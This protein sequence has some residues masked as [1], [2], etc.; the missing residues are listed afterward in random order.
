EAFLE[1]HPEFRLVEASGILAQQHIVLDTGKYLKLAPHV[2][3]T[4]GFFAAAMEKSA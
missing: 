2:H 3:G 1:A 4:D